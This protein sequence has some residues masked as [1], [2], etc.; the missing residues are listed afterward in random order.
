MND[1]AID[2]NSSQRAPH[3]AV[4]PVNRFISCTRISTPHLRTTSAKC[5]PESLL[6]NAS[7][8]HYSA[9]RGHT[10]RRS[11]MRYEQTDLWPHLLMPYWDARPGIVASR[12][13]C[14]KSPA[15]RSLSIANFAFHPERHRRGVTIFYNLQ[16]GSYFSY[17]SYSTVSS[18]PYEQT[19]L[20]SITPCRLIN[21]TQQSTQK[22]S[23]QKIKRTYAPKVEFVSCQFSAGL[24]FCSCV[25]CSLVVLKFQSLRIHLPRCRFAFFQY[26][27]SFIT[28][29]Q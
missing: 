2:L 12:T 16:F 7:T 4:S 1:L 27:P 20:Y 21:K 9:R 3:S 23:N 11:G 19:D 8:E 24:A 22:A 29:S 6:R 5:P 17:C 18:R 25:F 14:S 28:C 13:V 26:N 10:S 15:Q